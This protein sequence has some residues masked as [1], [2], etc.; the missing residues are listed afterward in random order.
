M[1]NWIAGSS[2]LRTAS[3]SLPQVSARSTAPMM[4]RL[5]AIGPNFRA[6][7]H[8]AS[9]LPPP[10]MV[11][12]DIAEGKL[13]WTSRAFAERAR[14]QL[15]K[16]VAPPIVLLAVVGGFVGQPQ[17]D[18]RAGEQHDSTTSGRDLTRSGRSTLA[19]ASV[20]GPSTLGTVRHGS[21]SSINRCPYRAVPA[22][23][24]G[25]STAT[26]MATTGR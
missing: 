10:F 21:K 25:W 3:R 6:P 7:F 23:V 1:R 14:A 22:R 13:F 11:V 5:S 15:P 9:N 4:H 2:T 24:L 20:S 26:S 17:D 16:G 8:A 18:H 19:N 12:G